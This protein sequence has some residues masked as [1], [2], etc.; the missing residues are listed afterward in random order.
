MVSWISNLLPRGL[1]GLKIAL[2]NV[3]IC[4]IG[5]PKQFLLTVVVDLIEW[6]RRTAVP[7][8]ATIS[9]AWTVFQCPWQCGESHPWILGC[10]KIWIFKKVAYF[11]HCLDKICTGAYTQ[12]KKAWTWTKT[13]GKFY[14]LDKNKL[15]ESFTNKGWKE[16]TWLLRVVFAGR[17]H[18]WAHFWRRTP[19]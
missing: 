1:S 3:S 9:R 11:R 16:L 2:Q 10:K 18:N 17:S 15:F 12:K 5:K 13:I 14:T 19:S 7:C 4:K 8:R 6:T